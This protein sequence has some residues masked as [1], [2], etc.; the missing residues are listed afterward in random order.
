MNDLLVLDLNIGYKIRLMYNFIGSK[1]N[2]LVNLLLIVKE[3]FT[4]YN[5][6]IKSHLIIQ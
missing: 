6:K 2:M 4:L 1:A 5:N 3:I